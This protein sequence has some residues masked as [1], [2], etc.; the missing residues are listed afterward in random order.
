M[1]VDLVQSPQAVFV[2]CYLKDLNQSMG[3]TT[4]K[5]QKTMKNPIDYI[6]SSTQTKIALDIIYEESE[7]NPIDHVNLFAK[8][9]GNI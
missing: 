2:G 3:K 1:Q 4:M 5:M 9:D 8:K 6:N 7:V